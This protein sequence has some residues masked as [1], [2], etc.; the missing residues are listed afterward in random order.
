MAIWHDHML[1]TNP[2]CYEINLYATNYT[3]MLTTKPCNRG[4]CMCL[5]CILCVVAIIALLVG[6]QQ[7]LSLLALLVQKYK[8]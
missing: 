3:S 4:P 1:L 6:L 5:C 7:V 8:Y 2:P